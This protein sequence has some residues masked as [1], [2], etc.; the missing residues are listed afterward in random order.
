[1]YFHVL[2]LRVVF[3]LKLF[4]FLQ[5]ES[6][7]ECGDQRMLESSFVQNE[8]H[9]QE[10]KGDSEPQEVDRGSKFLQ[11]ES[12]HSLKGPSPASQEKKDAGQR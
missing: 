12:V 6:H 11:A 3:F 5:Q 1:M 8:H 7:F 9:L 4:I 2:F 10:R